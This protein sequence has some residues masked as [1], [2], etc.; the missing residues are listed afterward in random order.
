MSF[1]GFWST[2]PGSS[3]T[4]RLQT[5]GRRAFSVAGTSAWN[6][7]PDNLRDPSVT[8]DGFRR[9]LKTHLFALC[10]EASSALEVL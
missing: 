9:L 7:L 8:R 4:P 5:Y 10:T 2:T 6:S 3:A 1:I